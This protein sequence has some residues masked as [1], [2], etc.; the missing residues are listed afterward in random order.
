MSEKLD[1]IIEQLKTLTLLEASEL[2]TDIEVP[3]IMIG[4]CCFAISPPFLFML[5]VIIVKAPTPR[6]QVMLISRM[7]TDVAVNIMIKVCVSVCEYVTSVYIMCVGVRVC[8]V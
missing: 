3:A 6:K 1:A 2:V 7:I 8:I 4:L 5:D